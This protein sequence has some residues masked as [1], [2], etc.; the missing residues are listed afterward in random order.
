M[1]SG[2]AAWAA[3]SEDFSVWDLN[4]CHLPAPQHARQSRQGPAPHARASSAQLIT[5]VLCKFSAHLSGFPC[6]DTKERHLSN[7]LGSSFPS[8]CTPAIW[9][10]E[11][12]S[13]LQ[14]NKSHPLILPPL[15]PFYSLSTPLLPWLTIQRVFGECK[16][17]KV[18]L[19]H[20]ASVPHLAGL[21]SGHLRDS[22]Q[23]CLWG[24]G[25]TKSLQEVI[26]ASK[27]VWC[28][29]L[30]NQAPPVQTLEELG[31]PGADMIQGNAG[32]IRSCALEHCDRG[33]TFYQHYLLRK[34]N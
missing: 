21:E 1:S 4:Y 22:F 15:P 29:C 33:K 16:I 23:E 31:L 27:W 20:C 9:W 19:P 28:Q 11:F 24:W 6:F 18:M 14:G 10:W 26:I 25:G 12:N 13:K 34:D 8:W 32:E 30:W 5:P 7:R 2:R 17:W 3:P